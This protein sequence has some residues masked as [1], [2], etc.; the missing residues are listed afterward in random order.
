MAS[1]WPHS[2]EAIEHQFAGV[3]EDERY[4]ILAG[5]MLRLYGV[6]AGANA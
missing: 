5:N 4:P 3:P 2:R 1:D 6:H